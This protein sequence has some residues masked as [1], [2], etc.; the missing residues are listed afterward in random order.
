MSTQ[1]GYQL[2]QEWDWPVFAPSQWVTTNVGNYGYG[3]VD[4]EFEAKLQGEVTATTTSPFKNPK[5]KEQKKIKVEAYLF[6]RES[7]NFLR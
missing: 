6:I 2:D 4:M 5:C 3:C 7:L 1:S